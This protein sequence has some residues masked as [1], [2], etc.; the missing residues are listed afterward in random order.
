MV[1]L[2]ALASL[3]AI[4]LTWAK[5]NGLPPV[6]GPLGGCETVETSAYSTFLGIPVAFYGLAASAVTM[7]GSLRWWRR[8]DGR[9]LML[10][11]LIGLASLPILAYLVYLELFVIGAVCAWCVLYAIVTVLGW[12]TAGVVLYRRSRQPQSG[13]P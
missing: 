12:L 6:C 2:A 10:A 11:Y 7:T 8:G 13:T 5:L 3:I 1:A 9:G 4:Y